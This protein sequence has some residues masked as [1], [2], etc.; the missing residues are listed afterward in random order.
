MGSSPE[1]KAVRIRR[2]QAADWA[3]YREIRLRALRDAPDA[4]GTAA[5]DAEQLTER[6]WRHRLAGRV[7]FAA[8]AGSAPVGL[9][10][11]IPSDRPGEAELISMWVDPGWRARG[12]G[13][14]LVETV[15]EWAADAGFS[16]LRLWVASGNAGAERL[17]SRYGFT[18]TGE[19]QPMGAGAPD[20]MEFA[21]VRGVG[22]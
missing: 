20:R 7:T 17:Y 11:G 5:G 14:Q 10:S 21:M 18:K 6:D 3:A 9:V 4:F 12:I 13:G 16:S 1:L 2:W 8:V 22:D 19:L 15:F